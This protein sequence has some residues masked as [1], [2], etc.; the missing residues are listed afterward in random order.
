MFAKAKFLGPTNTKP[1]RIKIVYFY[2]SGM[3]FKTKTESFHYKY[4]TVVDQIKEAHGLTLLFEESKWLYF[5]V[6]DDHPM[7]VAATL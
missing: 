4:S 5:T 7:A 3:V 2:K 6:P 1:S